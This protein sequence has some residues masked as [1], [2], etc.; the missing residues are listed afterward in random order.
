MARRNA[1]HVGAS[2]RV[3]LEVR[4]SGLNTRANPSATS[5]SC[6]LKSITA[7]T[8]LRRAASEAPTM[9]TPTSRAMT[10]RATTTSQGLPLRG[11]QKMPR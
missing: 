11:P 9:L 1:S 8:M 4:I 6:V 3:T 10:P 2:P 5:S 7:S